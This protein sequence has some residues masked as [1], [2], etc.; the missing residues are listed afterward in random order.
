MEDPK[1]NM[2]FKGVHD[3]YSYWVS[4]HPLTVFQHR[5]ARPRSVAKNNKTIAIPHHKLDNSPYGLHFMHDLT[6][7]LYRCLVFQ[8]Q[9]CLTSHQQKMES[10]IQPILFEQK[11]ITFQ[12]IN[13]MSNMWRP[14]KSAKTSTKILVSENFIIIIIFCRR[15][16]RNSKMYYFYAI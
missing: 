2:N 8:F 4:C 15:K 9:H 11:R 16:I 7:S 3:L 14:W 10:E 6:L 12:L 13:A 1:Q 5:P